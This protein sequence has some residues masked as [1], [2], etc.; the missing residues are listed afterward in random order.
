MDVFNFVLQKISM[1]QTQRPWDG[2]SAAKFFRDCHFDFCRHQICE[3][4]KAKRRLMAVYALRF[5]GT[6][7]RPKPP[8]H[9]I[10]PVRSR[11]ESQPIYSARFPDP[12]SGAYMVV[13]FI[14]SISERLSLFRGK[15][16]TLHFRQFKKAL[17]ALTWT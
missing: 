6:V 16:P 2:N 9:Q 13:P 8:N 1:M 11:E 4:M 5:A 15:I 12:V 10:R 17:L 3:L 14:G 7:S